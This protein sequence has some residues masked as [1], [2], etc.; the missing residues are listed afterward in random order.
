[1]KC[2]FLCWD[3]VLEIRINWVTIFLPNLWAGFGGAWTIETIEFWG[4]CYRPFDVSITYEGAMSFDL[5]DDVNP[6]TGSFICIVARSVC[7]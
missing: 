6:L 2:S 5:E 1:M 3:H 7:V 4:A